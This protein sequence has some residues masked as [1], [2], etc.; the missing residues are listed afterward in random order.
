MS[1]VSD[2]EAMKLWMVTKLRSNVH[3]KD[4]C[5]RDI[6]FYYGEINISP[7]RASLQ[8]GDLPISMA[9]A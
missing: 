3:L 9:P 8:S 5:S 4:T 7:D 6:I 2:L 1:A